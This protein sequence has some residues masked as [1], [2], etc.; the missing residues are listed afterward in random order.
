MEVY[1]KIKNFE[2]Y[3]VSNLGNIINIKTK[4]I[5]KKELTKGYFRVSLSKDGTVSR[6]QIHRLVASVFIINFNEKPCVNH[7]N[8][9]KTDNRVENLEWVSYS[10]N[11]RHS[12]DVLNKINPI[13]PNSKI[14]FNNINNKGLL[15]NLNKN[16]NIKG[17]K[18]GLQVA[19]SET[20]FELVSEY[21]LKSEIFFPIIK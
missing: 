13:R 15:V 6:F 3:K 4:R 20:I 19:F 21:T 18:G 14:D 8:G 11:E 10:E 7:I 16:D 1:R 2:N 12:Y 9:V 5:L 17:Q